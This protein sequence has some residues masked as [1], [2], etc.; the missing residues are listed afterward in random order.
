MFWSKET[1]YKMCLEECQKNNVYTGNL[2][3]KSLFLGYIK[4]GAF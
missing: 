4:N 3:E 2:I 1:A